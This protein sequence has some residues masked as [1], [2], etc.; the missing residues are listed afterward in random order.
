MTWIQVAASMMY[1]GCYAE[2]DEFINPGYPLSAFTTELTGI[3]DDH[4]KMG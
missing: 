4:L 1:K 2:F 3:T